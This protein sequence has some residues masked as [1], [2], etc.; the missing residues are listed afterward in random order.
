MRQ[1]CLDTETTGLNAKTGDRIV[2]IGAVEIVGRTLSDEPNTYFHVYI[3]PER[4]VPA[5]AVAV[6]GLSNER[7][8]NEPVFAQ[9]AQDFV[10]FIR[11]A[12]LII[13]NAEFDIGF[14]NAELKR[15]K[16]G[17]V[18]DYCTKVTDSLAMAKEIFPGLRN[19]L[20]ALCSRYEIDN[21]ERTFHGAL[22]DSQLLAE[23][24]LAM[25][26]K[27]G[28]LLGDAYEAGEEIDP[29]P[30]AHL[31]AKAKTPD[32]EFETHQA[33]LA[34]IEKK[35]KKGCLWNLALANNTSETDA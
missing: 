11:G 8:A 21:S 16:L 19:T 12:E 32:D 30:A 24:Y 25:T 20:D 29:V 2:E 17:K 34:M 18:S 13:H 1:I 22:L 3:N 27:Q 15:A 23:V 7:L 14:L 10:E 26:R 9:I 6:H 31:F 35:S 5:E 28:S 33:F 4:D